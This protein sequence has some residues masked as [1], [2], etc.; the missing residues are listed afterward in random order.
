[1]VLSH[2]RLSFL[3]ILA[4]F[5]ISD[6]YFALTAALITFI[7]WNWHP[8]KIFMGDVGSTFWEL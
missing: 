2:C 1:M 6:I 3:S 8:A 7:F 5:Y 4:G